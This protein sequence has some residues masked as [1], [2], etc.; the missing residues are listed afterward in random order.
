MTV[1]RYQL[2]H[3]VGLSVDDL[4]RLGY[5]ECLRLLKTHEQFETLKAEKKEEKMDEHK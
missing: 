4:D 5:H 2:I 3:E 1:L